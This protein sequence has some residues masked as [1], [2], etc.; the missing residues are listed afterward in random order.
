MNLKLALGAAALCAVVTLSSAAHATEI[1]WTLE[2]VTWAM[3]LIGVGVI[4]ASMRVRRR[5]GMALTAA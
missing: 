1:L 2:N 4:G 3:M 5:N